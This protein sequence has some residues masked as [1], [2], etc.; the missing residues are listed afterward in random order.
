MHWHPRRFVVY[1][2]G[3]LL[4]VVGFAWML[5]DAPFFWVGAMLLALGLLWVVV[6]SPSRPSIGS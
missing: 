5:G 4:V 1:L 2:F 6:E 3:V